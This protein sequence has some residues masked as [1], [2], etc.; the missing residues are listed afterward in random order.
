MPDIAERFGVWFDLNRFL[1][2]KHV[3]H[4]HAFIKALT[5][6]FGHFHP[7]LVQMITLGGDAELQLVGFCRP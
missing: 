7:Q 6:D 2:V 3:A 5:C 4:P 1:T